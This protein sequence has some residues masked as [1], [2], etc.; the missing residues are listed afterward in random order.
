MQSSKFSEGQRIN[1]VGSN[2]ML[3]NIRRII[4]KFCDKKCALQIV[5]LVEQF[6]VN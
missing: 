3:L 6:T 2:K 5:T 4:E 1:N